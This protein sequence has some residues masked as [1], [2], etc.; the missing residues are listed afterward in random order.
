MFIQPC[1]V[2]TCLLTLEK[3]QDALKGAATGRGEDENIDIDPKLA[4]AMARY[5]DAAKFQTKHGKV[6]A[7][8]PGE[9]TPSRVS[10]F[11][12]ENGVDPRPAPSSSVM[13]QVAREMIE[14]QKKMLWMNSNIPDEEEAQRL[15]RRELYGEEIDSDED[16]SIIVQSPLPDKFDPTSLDAW[17]GDFASAV[18]AGV[19]GDGSGASPSGSVDAAS[20]LTKILRTL[21]QELDGNR[22]ALY[23]LQD[24]DQTTSVVLRLLEARKRGPGEPCL[25]F[26]SLVCRRIEMIGERFTA[27]TEMMKE[28]SVEGGG[29][30]VNL[31]ASEGAV[32]LLRSVLRTNR[33]RIKK[34]VRNAKEKHWPK[35]TKYSVLVAT[36]E[37][38][39]DRC[40]ICGTLATKMCSGCRRVSYCS[41]E[42]QHAHWK[43]H[44]KQCS[45][46]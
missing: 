13:L 37:M 25:V 43:V 28:A 42:H 10:E 36:P 14:F 20:D 31:E 15:G 2:P 24:P 35:F 17:Q 9:W 33:R 38:G 46:K 4:E 45:P 26:M 8:D 1:S 27:L 3:I 30:V 6:Q 22:E 19:T 18:L 32:E 41:A 39:A 7:G 11:L 16:L 40:P 44:K 12:V 21:A 5:Q 34:S 29:G 23:M